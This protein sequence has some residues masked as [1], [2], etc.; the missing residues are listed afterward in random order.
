M[1]QD[2]SNHIVHRLCNYK[3]P[4]LD[5]TAE[6][7]SKYYSHCIVSLTGS[8]SN[9]TFTVKIRSTNGKHKVVMFETTMISMDSWVGQVG[10][11]TESLKH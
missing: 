1:T 8:M 7:H 5:L 6:G 10:L 2:G 11:A 9:H 3:L 4:S